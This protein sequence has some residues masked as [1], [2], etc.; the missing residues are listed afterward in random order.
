MVFVSLGFAP[1]FAACSC[2]DQSAAKPN[3]QEKKETQPTKKEPT[4]T[5]KSTEKTDMILVAGCCNDKESATCKQCGEP[6]KDGK[7]P[8][9]DGAGKSGAKE[10]K[11]CPKI[12]FA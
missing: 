9:C 10:N 2:S 5:Q 6:C 4:A 1:A 11:G 3:A 8:V 7:C 12:A